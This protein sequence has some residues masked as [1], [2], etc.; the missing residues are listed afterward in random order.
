M[1]ATFY[2]TFSITLVFSTVLVNGLNVSEQ[3]EQSQNTI[4]PKNN[5]TLSNEFITIDFI[6]SMI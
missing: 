1:I 5:T 3:I 4:V 2:S 6:L